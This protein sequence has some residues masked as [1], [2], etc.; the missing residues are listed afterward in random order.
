[1]DGDLGKHVRAAIAKV[2]LIAMDKVWNN[3]FRQ[4]T[5]STRPIRRPP[6]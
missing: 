5:S 1:M 4:I 6:I 2:G 3:G